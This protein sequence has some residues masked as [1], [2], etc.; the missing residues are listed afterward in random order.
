MD[1]C[2]QIGTMQI[3]LNNFGLALRKS[4]RVGRACGVVQE[5]VQ[6][7]YQL[8]NTKP[9]LYLNDLVESLVLYEELLEEDG[10]GGADK[11][12]DVKGQLFRLK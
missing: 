11:V 12:A 2:S 7:R 4:G 8:Y 10:S 3:R 1:R 6:R 9:T 5:A